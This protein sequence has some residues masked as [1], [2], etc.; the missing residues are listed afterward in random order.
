MWLMIELE[1]EWVNGGSGRTLT[2]RGGELT[3]APRFVGR[4][5][6]VF[7]PGEGALSYAVLRS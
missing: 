7:E 2:V 3:L 6:R 5:W 4:G 1:G